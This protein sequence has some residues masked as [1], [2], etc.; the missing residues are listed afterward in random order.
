MRRIVARPAAG[1]LSVLR[2]T[3]I[4]AHSMYATICRSTVAP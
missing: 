3:P 1:A 4:G 2:F